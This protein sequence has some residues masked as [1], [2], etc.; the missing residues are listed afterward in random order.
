MNILLTS[1]GRRSYMVNYFKDALKGIGL[2]HA[3][4]SNKTYAMQLADKSLITPLIFDESYIDFL[5]NYCIENNINAIISLFDIDLP[6][7]ATHRTQF[8]QCGID[9]LVSDY[10]TTQICNDKWLT[11][12]FLKENRLMR[13]KRF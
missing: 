13:L 2:V 10:E 5:L 6:I 1:V 4:N 12:L 8:A 9:V 7:L 3:A 11:Y